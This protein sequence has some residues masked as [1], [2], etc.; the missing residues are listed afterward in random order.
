MQKSCHLVAEGFV[1]A[2]VELYIMMPKLEDGKIISNS[3][4][5]LVKS[6]VVNGHVSSLK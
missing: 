2:A 1:D 4:S 5:F 6:M 3:G